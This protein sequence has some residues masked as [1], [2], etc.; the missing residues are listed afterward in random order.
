V[1][2]DRADIECPLERNLAEDA[3][4]GELRI[5]GRTLVVMLAPSPSTTGRGWYEKGIG[6][7][8]WLAFAGIGIG[9]L[10]ACSKL[11]GD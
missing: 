5:P 7:L 3:Q 10:Y 1:A 4:L 2:E 8:I 9:T 11:A 6:V